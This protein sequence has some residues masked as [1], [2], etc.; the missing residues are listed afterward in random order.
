VPLLSVITPTQAHNADWLPATSASVL[1]STLPGGWDL[2]W[3]IQE[4]GA[5]PGLGEVVGALADGDARV[6]YDA[7]GVQAGS[8]ATRNA[9]LV[10]ARG[11]LVVGMDHDDVFAPGGAAALVSALVDAPGAAWACGRCDWLLPDGGHWAKD[12]VL[13]AGAVAPGTITTYL[14][15][16]GDWPFP[17]A[18]ACYRRDVLLAA[19]GWPAMV[20]SEDAGLLLG[21]AHDHPGVWVD[22]VV[23]TYRR[24]EGQKTV[25]RADITL[26]G[27]AAAALRARAEALTGR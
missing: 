2:E 25:S 3:L 1:T 16:T 4:D 7:L 9:A 18:F 24:W 19:G 15:A 22:A 23:A 14:L 20:R 26:R 12:D 8:G 6:R 13:P 27:A 21:I 10:R 17:A 5:A 11:E